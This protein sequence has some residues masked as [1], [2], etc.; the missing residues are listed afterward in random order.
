MRKISQPSRPE[1]MLNNI[2]GGRQGN[3]PYFAVQACLIKAMA[4]W[5]LTR[6]EDAR[7]TLNGCPFSQ[8]D[9]TKVKGKD[10]GITWSDWLTCEILRRELKGLM[11]KEAAASPASGQ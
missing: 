4:Q 8:D 11:E 10:Y 5:Q 9:K 6:S 3:N 2:G 7:S 1:D